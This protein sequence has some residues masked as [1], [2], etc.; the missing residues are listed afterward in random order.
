MEIRLFFKAAHLLELVN[1]ERWA[2]AHEYL[3]RFSALWG[4]DDGDAAATQYAVLLRCLA[5]NSSLDWFARRGDEGGRAASLLHPPYDAL[6][7]SHPEEAQ[8]IDMY[9]SMASQQARY[10]TVPI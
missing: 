7:Q 1:Q 9:R 5:H 6:R 10:G 8:R 2:E 4:D 3:E